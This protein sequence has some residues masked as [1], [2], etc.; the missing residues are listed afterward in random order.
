MVWV[1]VLLALLMVNA[2]QGRVALV[3]GSGGL[4][5]SGLVARLRDRGWQV[6]EVSRSQRPGVS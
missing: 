4:V 6:Q 5:G 3:L 1:V 2:A